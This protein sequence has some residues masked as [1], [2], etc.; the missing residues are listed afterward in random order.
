MNARS[1]P[2]SW[3]QRPPTGRYVL[4]DALGIDD[5]RSAETDALVNALVSDGASLREIITAL[6][7]REMT[8]AEFAT[9][10]YALGWFDCQMRGPESDE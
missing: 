8:D 3:V 4:G 10:M 1:H 2:L 7:E 6:S 5:G 9:A